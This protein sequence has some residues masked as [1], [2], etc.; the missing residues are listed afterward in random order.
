MISIPEN[1]AGARDSAA[2]PAMPLVPVVDELEALE[3]LADVDGSVVR[4]AASVWRDR[5]SLLP[6]RAR[7]Q[8]HTAELGRL[9]SQ[10]HEGLLGAS[11]EVRDSARALALLINTANVA[12]VLI[13]HRTDADYRALVGLRRAIRAQAKRSGNAAVHNRAMRMCG[14]EFV[15][16]SEAG[17]SPAKLPP[18]APSGLDARP[19]EAAVYPLA[20]SSSLA[21]W[22][23][24]GADPRDLLDGAREWLGQIDVWRRMQTKIS[25]PA[26]LV[27]PIRGAEL[28][29]YARLARI[30][31]W[32]ARDAEEVA[33][34]A[35]ALDL[36]GPRDH[37]PDPM[38]AAV[39]WASELGEIVPPRD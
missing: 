38:R 21:L 10:V 16:L 23:A 30:G 9:L 32:P 19:R 22:Q 3:L 33:I 1:D 25:N 6:I 27:D 5:P 31:L 26:L 17:M 39:S 36:I 29:A 14:G 37:D 8:F 12:T 28:L 4:R 13:A 2:A 11:D 20:L 34:K 35:A 24:T 7:A 15:A 18:A